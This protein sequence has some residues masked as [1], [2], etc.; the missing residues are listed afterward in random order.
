MNDLV[1]P[2]QQSSVHAPNNCQFLSTGLILAEETTID[3]WERIGRFLQQAE[4]SLQWWIGDWLRF[5]ERK[6]GKTY[7]DAAEAT[8]YAVKSLQ[9]F[10]S[11]A[12]QVEPSKRLEDLPWTYHLAV[13]GLKP[14]EQE[15]MLRR[16]RNEGWKHKDLRAAV[17]VRGRERKAEVA[18][19]FFDAKLE[20]ARLAWQSLKG[21]VEH[22][23]KEYPR[24]ALYASDFI[25]SIE[26]ELQDASATPLDYLLSKHERGARSWDALVKATGFTIETVERLVGELIEQ[27]KLKIVQRGG[28]TDQARGAVEDVIAA[29]NDPVGLDYRYSDR[30]EDDDDDD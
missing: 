10:A 4:Q 22:F 29:F 14:T 9:M 19:E 23:A 18:S 5:G 25:G 30:R 24:F 2:D 15:R 6:Y 21:S 12:K 11:V 26:E 1:L 27:K 13:A 28:K 7:K 16:A 17:A 3:E 8:G 20:F